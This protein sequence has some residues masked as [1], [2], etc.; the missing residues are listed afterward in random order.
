MSHQTQQSNSNTN[1]PPL[2]TM[3]D[4]NFFKLLEEATFNGLDMEKVEEFCAE[5]EITVDYYIQEFI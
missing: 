2:S 3:S 1:Q 4:T 5:H